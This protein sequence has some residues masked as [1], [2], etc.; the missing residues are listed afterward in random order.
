M[1]LFMLRGFALWSREGNKDISQHRAVTE[2]S[3]LTA[4]RLKQQKR[5]LPS[6]VEG[7][8][9]NVSRS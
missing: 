3:Q 2:T 7:H 5:A 9:P 6:H 4:S 1:L 8:A